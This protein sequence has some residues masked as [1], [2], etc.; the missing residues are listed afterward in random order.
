MSSAAIMIDALRVKSEPDS[1][2]V[3]KEENK[4]ANRDWIDHQAC[5]RFDHNA[6]NMH[7]QL[8]ILTIGL[9]LELSITVNSEIFARD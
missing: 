6:L 8:P 2:Y 7:T 1:R 3:I 9:F 5:S 4:V